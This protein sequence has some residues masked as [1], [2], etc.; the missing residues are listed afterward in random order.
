[1]YPKKP[2]LPNHLPSTSS[3]YCAG[4]HTWDKNKA[5]DLGI[6]MCKGE[7]IEERG[8][9]E[10]HRAMEKSARHHGITSACG[11]YLLY[12]LL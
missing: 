11:M 9:K 5:G 2:V 3:P 7:V 1:M 10:A 8:V 4:N 6:D 12:D